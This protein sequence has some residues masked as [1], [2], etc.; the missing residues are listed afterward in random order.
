MIKGLIFDLDGTL[1]DSIGDIAFS[2]NLT[3]K[4]NGYETK[5]ETFVRKVTGRGFR[6]LIKDMLPENC[7]EETV[8]KITKEY[9]KNYSQHYCE[10]TKAYEG[11]YELLKTL[12]DK[13]IKLAVNSNKKDNMT[14]SLMENIF[15]EINFVDVLGERENTP[16]KPDPHSALELVAKMELNIDEVLYVGDS[17]VDMKTANNAKLKSVGCLWGFRDKDTLIN[18]GAA[19]IAEKPSDILGLLGNNNAAV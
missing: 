17:E 2:A 13:E 3:L 19:H 4:E 16:N 18:E 12:Q 9:T 10:R 7:D 6:K 15:P 5:D 14:K 1:I 8:D 11:I